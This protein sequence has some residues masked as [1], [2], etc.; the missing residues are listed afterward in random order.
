MGL[1]IHAV[2]NVYTG[3][4]S[5][6]ALGSA[7]AT[8]RLFEFS[9]EQMANAL[10]VAEYHAPRTPIMRGVEKPGMTKDGIGWGA[11]A[12]VVSAQLADTGFT[13]SGTVFDEASMD[14]TLGEVF[15][16]TK[17]YL[18]PYPCCRWAQPGVE[19]ILTLTSRY[20][21]DPTNVE[22]VRISTFEEATH[23]YTRKPERHRRKHNTLMRTRSPP[24]SPEDASRRPN[25]RNRR[26]RTQRFWQLPT[27]SNLSLM[28]SWTGDSQV[29]VLLAWLWRLS[30]RR[31]DPT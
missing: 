26:E 23:L 19:A 22:S 20:D 18:K 16:V 5:W 3:T 1:A 7:A 9:T 6:G 21:I 4:G 31:T 17:G 27:V 2:D 14:D 28:T 8:A 25:T 29:S 30:R 13:G 24:R 10:G 12:G 11:Y 15:H